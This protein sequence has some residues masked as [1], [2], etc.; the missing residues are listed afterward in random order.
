MT[1]LH[2]SHCDV[3]I[4]YTA[5]KGSCTLRG[6]YSKVQAAL[7][8]LLGHPGGPESAQTS[9]KPCTQVCEDQSK[10]PK[11]QREKN[12]I[13]ILSDEY[14]S[15][16][17]RDLTPGIHG[18]E[19]TRHTD[20]AALHPPATSV[21]DSSL[22]VDA[23]MFHYLRKH[24]S[25]EYQHILSQYGVEVIDETNQGLTT[26]F[27]HGAETAAMED[28]REQ[29]RLKLA[30]KAISQL[31]QENESKIRRAQLPKAILSPRGGLQRALQNLSV[32]FP[33][34]LLNEDEQNI[35]IIGSS[36]DVSDAKSS[37]L[38]DLDEVRHKKEDVYDFG[39]SS[40]HA[41]KH[42]VPHPM[43][44]TVGSLDPER[45][46]QMVGSE[47]DEIRAGGVKKYKLAARFKDSG[48]PA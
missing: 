34:L 21:E 20:S 19:D 48:L 25:K 38:L 27:F 41:D 3:Q 13:S 32:R 18:W 8:Q 35:Y 12:H 4:N 22:I 45:T 33:K 17:E 9:Q 11:Q 47:E 23:D 46:D 30:R 2:K 31:Y 39:S 5:N 44:S 15:S 29:E 14:N 28:G 26:L 37:L 7:A 6:S 43:P 10:K 1:S 16:S 24:C 36:S 42:R 40:T